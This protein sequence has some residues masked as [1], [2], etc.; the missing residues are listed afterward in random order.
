MKIAFNP[1]SAA[2]LTQAPSGDYLKAITF[3]LA[4]HNIFTRGEMFKGTDTTYQT[5][6]KATQNAVGYDGLVPAP[7]YTTSSVR[8]LRE[9]G[10]WILPSRRE[11]KLGGSNFINASDNKA[12]DIHAGDF[13][14]ITSDSTGKI[15]ISSTLEV[16][17]DFSG[18]IADAF[19]KVKVG[20]ST[21]KASTSQELAFAAGTAI[22]LTPN[23]TTNT[24]Q[25][26]AKTMTG[27]TSSA[28]GTTGLVPAPAANKH[29]SFLRG[30]GTWAT[31]DI[32]DYG[33]V[34]ASSDGVVPKFDA[35]DGTIDSSS[36]D[37]VLTNNNGSLGWYKL[38]ANAFKNDNTTY[39]LSGT[40]NSGYKITLTPSSGS[41]T[42]ATVPIMVGASADAN[43]NIGLVPA[44]TKGNQGKYLRADGT[45]STP[46][47]THYTTH[48]Y[49]GAQS[50][51]NSNNSNS[52]TTNGNTYI[53]LFDNSTLR[54]QYKI[55]G[56]G[57]V[58]VASDTSGNIT[59]N[60]PTTISWDNVS[61]KPSTFA[62]S[63]HNH[64]TSQIN[65]LTGY[66]KAEAVSSLTTSDSLNTALG[67]LEYK[68]D[69]AY[70][71]V[72]T[73]SDDDGTIENLQEVLKVLS[74]IKDTETIKAIIGKYLPLTGGTLSG[75]L[76]FSS[77]SAISW[78][79]GTYQQRI[80]LTDDSTADTAV[81]TFQQSSDSAANWTDLFTIKDNGN[82]I[83][84]KFI[85]SGGTASQFVKGD[86]SLDSTSYATTASLGN[87]VTLATTQT[88][89]G[90]KTFSA[91]T[92]I[93]NTLTVKGNIVSGTTNTYTLGTSSNV[94]KNI[95][96]TNGTFTSTVDASGFKKSG[97]SDSYVL[98]GG[99]G[100]KA[101]STFLL[102]SEEL[103]NNVTT[104]S[105]ALTVTQDWMDTGTPLCSQLHH[106]LI[107][108]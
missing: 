81:F 7:S 70:D 21:L 18:T 91:A 100:H 41:A 52:E 42:D 38:P 95:Y 67:K 37:W 56:S 80:Y 60:V 54:H 25:I 6:R 74:G 45:W 40:I 49:V 78:N 57:R 27:A 84:S 8:F 68:L 4:G 92:T 77:T 73:A 93:N 89:S 65:S 33:L 83:A 19:T 62:P 30:D 15:T 88:I 104:K 97:S 11:I 63:S 69:I 102:K 36:T 29:E 16:E 14:S 3:D 99:G 34:T 32:R 87:Y 101:L 22:T 24:I 58:T 43:G 50:S 82:V 90:A 28:A 59:I 17:G 51:S 94:W 103:T 79:N 85:T 96:A 53:K 55:S 39:T 23:T 86:G 1:T 48:L 31:P 26:A 108:T 66:S 72:K 71:L 98:L 20:S 12:L 5:F 2:P 35:A 46:S 75:P 64:P 44:P 9:D 61:G 106:C 76:N 10:S 13:I 107:D 47:D 105:L